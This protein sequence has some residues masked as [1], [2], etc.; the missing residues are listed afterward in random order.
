MICELISPL[1][2][3]SAVVEGFCRGGSDDPQ[4]EERSL[5]AAQGSLNQEP[6]VL[7]HLLQPAHLL[8]RLQR[9]CLVRRQIQPWLH[10][11]CHCSATRGATNDAV[12]HQSICHLLSRLSLGLGK[13]VH[14]SF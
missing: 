11:S 1:S 8:L 4:Q 9:V 2:G 3:G 10:H 5:Q 7:R 12:Q 14:L 6:R 13:I